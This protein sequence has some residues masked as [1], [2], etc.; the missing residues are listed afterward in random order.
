[1]VSRALFVIALTGWLACSAAE[2][3]GLELTLISESA[4]LTPGQPIT[5]GLHIAHEPGYH[6]YWQNPG[7]V[8][9]ATSLEWDL[10]PGFQASPPQWPHPENCLMAGHPSFGY[11]RDVTLLVTITPPQSIVTDTVTLGCQARWMCCA[12]TCHPGSRKLTLTLPVSAS[13][14]PAPPRH[15]Q[16]LDQAR[17]E[18]PQP[19]RAWT[20]TLLSPASAPVIKLQLT[21]K[22]DQQPLTLFSNDGQISS[23]PKVSF[24]K[25]GHHTWVTSLPRAEFSPPSPSS[26]PFV[27]QTT[28]GYHQLAAT[29]PA[30]ASAT[31]SQS[32]S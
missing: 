8:G 32:D 15:Q 1:M 24:E 13:P 18:I 29:F 19:S 26:L 2:E 6:T 4:T 30:E 17:R 31:T 14:S 10:P 25:K 22:G 27:L 11:E 3:A 28:N 20:T 9:V 5:V 21:H 23:L 7:I 16:W 12:E